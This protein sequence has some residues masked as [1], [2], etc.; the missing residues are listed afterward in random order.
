[1]IS[2]YWPFLLK[3]IAIEYAVLFNVNKISAFE[4]SSIF[5]FQIATSVIFNV[6]DKNVDNVSALQI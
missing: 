5:L 3:K 6:N 2:S 1:M 4:T